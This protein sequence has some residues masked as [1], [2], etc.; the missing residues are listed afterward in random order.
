MF[1]LMFRPQIV[2]DFN[3]IKDWD[4]NLTFDQAFEE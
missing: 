1:G 2:I 4:Q 3:L